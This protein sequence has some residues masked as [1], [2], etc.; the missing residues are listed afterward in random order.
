MTAQER[1]TL[2][3][4]KLSDSS[5]DGA[6]AALIQHM[7]GHENTRCVIYAPQ[8]SDQIPRS[9][10]AHAFSELQRTLLHYE[11]VRLC[12]FWDYEDLDG[13]SIPTIVALADSRDVT[14]LV[15]DDHFS[16]YDKMDNDLGRRHGEKARRRLR[17]AVRSA[18]GII[19]SDLLRQTKNYRDKL[20][21]QLETTQEERNATAP[22]PLPKY[23]DERKLLDRTVRVVDLLYSSLNGT[24]F[25]WRGTKAMHRRNAEAL[26][27]GIRVTVLR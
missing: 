20:A 10:A 1:L 16:H 24:S 9:Y 27:L 6:V 15:F 7:R 4:S 25:D 13:R 11:I 14:Q 18:K 26:W 3:R 12:T 5:D 21:H 19:A 8:L 23:G 22:I 17:E 2:A